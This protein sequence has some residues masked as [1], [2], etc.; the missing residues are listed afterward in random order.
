MTYKSTI[1]GFT[2]KNKSLSATIIDWF[3]M[4]NDNIRT[5]RQ[6]FDL[7]SVSRDSLAQFSL[8]DVPRS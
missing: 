1:D 7:F 4:N 5:S 2:D 6:L 3:P 8:S